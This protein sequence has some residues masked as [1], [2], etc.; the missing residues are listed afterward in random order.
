M[1]GHMNVTTA[2]FGAEAQSSG[3]L[4]DKGIRVP[5]HLGSTMRCTSQI[6]VL[7]LVFFCL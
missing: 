5:I 4:K 7:V 2:C 1:H 3:S 6:D